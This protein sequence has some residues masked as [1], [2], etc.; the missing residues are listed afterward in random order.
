MIFSGVINMIR[1]G[2]TRGPR[3]QTGVTIVELLSGIA[4][5]ALVGGIMVTSMWELTRA[6]EMGQAQQAVTIQVR[7]ATLWLERDI[8]RASS[9]NVP[10]PG[11]P[12]A[13]AQFDWTDEIGPHSCVYEL[14]GTDLIRTCDSVPTTV[15]KHLSGLQF[16]R[17]GQ[18]LT[19][20]FTATA[21]ELAT[22]SE[23]VS[24]NLAMRSS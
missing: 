23:T 3:R 7:A 4:L 6:S 16:T 18:L 5:S 24:I 19:V 10:D 8:S 9:S 21:P 15:A 13:S 2:L 22:T 1:N 12:L 20:G 14:T 11:A 17:S